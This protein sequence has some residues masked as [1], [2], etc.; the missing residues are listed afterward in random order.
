MQGVPKMSVRTHVRT[1]SGVDVVIDS[2]GNIGLFTRAQGLMPLADPVAVAE[3]I[4][5]E[6]RNLRRWEFEEMEEDRGD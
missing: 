5:Q 3:A 4:L 1:G 6:V 2:E